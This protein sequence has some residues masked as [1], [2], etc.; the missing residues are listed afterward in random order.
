MLLIGAWAEGLEAEFFESRVESLIQSA[1]YIYIPS[2]LEI[3]SQTK[4]R[5]LRKVLLGAV[6]MLA[7]LLLAAFAIM[8]LGLMPV[9]A[10]GPHSNLE[11]RIMPAV[12]H[13]SISRH[14]PR[15]TNPVR[16]NEDNLKAAVDTYKAVCARC[17]SSGEAR[18]VFTVNRSTRRRHNFLQEWPSTQNR[19]SSG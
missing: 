14:A 16:L 12:L 3:L 9:C 19:N 2:T 7:I 8:E 13:A 11:A 5:A 17:H 6:L 15:E 10:D 1:I 18:R 4:E